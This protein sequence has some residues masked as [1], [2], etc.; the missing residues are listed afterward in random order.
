MIAFDYGVKNIGVAVG[1]SLTQSATPLTELK[2]RDGI[3]NW[4]T[5]GDLFEEWQPDA[6]LIGLPLNMDGTESDM[7]KRARKFGNRINGRFGLK[8]HFVDERLS[9]KEAKTR[10]KEDGHKGNYGQQPIDSLAASILLETWWFERNGKTD[11][12][13]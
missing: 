12:T 3:P 1:Q 2:A 7:C 4:Q 8:I 10:A 9:T 6:V 11:E 5:L 13:T